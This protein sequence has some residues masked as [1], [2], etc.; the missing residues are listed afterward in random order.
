MD[1]IAVLAQLR[2]FV[3]CLLG[4]PALR[5]DFRGPHRFSAAQAYFDG[6]AWFVGRPV[7]AIGRSGPNGFVVVRQPTT[8]D[9]VG[10]WRMEDIAFVIELP[11]VKTPSG[12]VFK[13]RA[14]GIK[15]DVPRC[16]SGPDMRL[17]H[18]AL[19]QVC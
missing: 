10:K 7:L 15:H 19:C 2:F 6:A 16:I 11:H 1:T 3:G 9:V 17:L 5:T 8:E 4:V 13:V 18:A 14:R 12:Q